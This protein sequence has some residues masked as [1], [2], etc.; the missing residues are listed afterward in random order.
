MRSLRFPAM[1]LFMA[2]LFASALSA[3]PFWEKKPFTEWSKSEC[4]KVLQDSPWAKRFVITHIQ[5]DRFG[6]STAGEGR[7]VEQRITYTAQ[8]RGALPVRQAVV[9]LAQIQNK[10]DKLSANDKKIFDQSAEAY[11]AGDTAN[12][13][14][15]HVEFES[16]VQFFEQALVQYWH[17]FSS[18]VMPAEVWLITASGKRIGAY[19][20]KI[21]PGGAAEFEFFFPRE[22]DGKPVISPEDKKIY[23]EFPNPRVRELSDTRARFEFQIEKMKYKGELI[24]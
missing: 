9:R 12:H 16:N 4:Q 7:Q 14:I 21:P 10:Y 3:Q 8:L 22:V 20:W 1:T 11:L 6:Q 23:F 13:I 17:S 15:V 18:G 5:E 19:S 2:L 24:Y